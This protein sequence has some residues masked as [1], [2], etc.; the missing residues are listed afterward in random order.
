MKKYADLPRFYLKPGEIYKSN[1]PEIIET[2]L[3]SCVAVIMYSVEKKFCMVSHAVLPT[4]KHYLERKKINEFKYVDTSISGML[5][6]IENLNIVKEQIKVKL[7]GG[8]EVF[9]VNTG[10]KSVGGQNIALAMEI[11]NEEKLKIIASDVGGNLG[12]KI[13]VASHTGEVLLTR[14]GKTGFGKK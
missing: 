9:S 12:R 8:A 6:E 2:V 1:K 11:L 7:F 4:A 13:I 3:G 5:R 10:H 14:L